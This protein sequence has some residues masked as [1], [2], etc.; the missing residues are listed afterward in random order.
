MTLNFFSW[1]YHGVLSSRPYIFSLPWRRTQPGIAPGSLAPC[2]NFILPRLDWRLTAARHNKTLSSSFGHYSGW[3][4]SHS[5]AF[6]VTDQLFFLSQAETDRIFPGHMHISFHII[7]YIHSTT[8]LLLLIYTGVSWAEKSLMAWFS[9]N[10]QQWFTLRID[11]LT[12]SI[13][14]LDFCWEIH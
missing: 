12:S 10:M 2:G 9:V 11:L 1:P 5:P 13:L 4:I 8:W 7:L 14:L 3:T 6:F